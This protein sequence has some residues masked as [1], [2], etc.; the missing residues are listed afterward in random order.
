MATEPPRP[1]EAARAPQLA[2]WKVV[3]GILL[4]LLAIGTG[5]FLIMEPKI[6][7]KKPGHLHVGVRFA[8]EGTVAFLGRN[9]AQPFTRVR[10]E[11]LVDSTPVPVDIRDGLRRGRNILTLEDLPPGLYQFTFSS[12]GYIPESFRFEKTGDTWL[13]LPGQVEPGDGDQLMEQFIGLR[14]QPEGPTPDAG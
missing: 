13:P 12:D 9:G 1:A 11:R 8:D 10:I 5:L 14:F 2:G 6:T 7:E 4:P 3:V